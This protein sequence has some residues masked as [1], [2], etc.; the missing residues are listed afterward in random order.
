MSIKRINSGSGHR[1]TIDGKPAVGVTTAL[2][3]LDKPAL[4]G[5]AARQVAEYVADNLDGLL[6]RL[7]TAGG[8]EPFINHLRAIPWQKRN[9]AAA[10]GTNVHN[11]ADLIHRGKFEDVDEEAAPYI[12]AYLAFL[13]DFDARVIRSEFVVAH[14]G[15]GYAGTADSIIAVDHPELSGTG[16][17]DIKTGKAVYGEYALQS[18][19]YRFAEVIAED[20]GTEAPMLQTDF[21]AV[22]HLSEHGYEVVPLQADAEAFEAFQH[23][24]WLWKNEIHGTKKTPSRISQRVLPAITRGVA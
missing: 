14:R 20:D 21:A 13:S 8:R 24:L 15:L 2:K 23:A 10:K 7:Y 18:A 16:L 6:D 11:I 22:I 12:E 3:A 17:F 4:V 5:W 9:D 1:Y 19:A